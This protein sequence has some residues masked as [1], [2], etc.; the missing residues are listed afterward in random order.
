MNCFCCNNEVPLA[1][2]V[3]IRRL[4][5]Y[6]PAQGGPESPQYKSFKEESTYRWSVIC[7]PCYIKLDN[8]YGFCEINSR[9]FSIAGCS[10]KDRARVMNQDDYQKWQVREAAKIG[11]DL[12]SNDDN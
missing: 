5:D 12:S 4:I 10:R 2:K 9:E 11:L 8:D 7:L 1:K 3:K 6:D